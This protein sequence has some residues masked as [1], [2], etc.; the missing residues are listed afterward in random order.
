MERTIAPYNFKVHFSVCKRFQLSQFCTCVQK[1]RGASNILDPETK[2]LKATW[3]GKE[4]DST[5]YKK[6]LGYGEY[7]EGDLTKL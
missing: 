2:T 1:T 5:K 7:E 6:N 4:A 3:E